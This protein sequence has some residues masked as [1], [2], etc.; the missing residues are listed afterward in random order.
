MGI[1]RPDDVAV[2]ERPSER[3]GVQ[4]VSNDQRAVTP[5]GL[6]GAAALGA[7]CLLL[8][9]P[10]CSN[11]SGGGSGSTTGASPTASAPASNAANRLTIQNF[12]FHPATLTVKSGAVVTVTNADSTAH[13]VTATGAKPFDT[14]TIAPGRTV[15]F[16]APKTAGS[17]PYIC[18]IHPFMKG[19][20]TVS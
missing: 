12:A 2:G 18:T 7:A 19:T 9:L 14:G 6:R 10:G 5:R 11:S 1:R 20:L 3:N 8:A 13:T 15:T 17:Y 16:T 4:Q